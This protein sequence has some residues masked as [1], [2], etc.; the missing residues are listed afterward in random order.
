MYAIEETVQFECSEGYILIGEK[1][2]KCEENGI[3]LPEV[4]ECRGKS[5]AAFTGKCKD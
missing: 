4:P 1:T 5:N 3:F 2:S